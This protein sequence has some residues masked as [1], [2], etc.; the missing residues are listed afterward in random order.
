MKTVFLFLLLSMAITVNVGAQELEHFDI[1]PVESGG[2]WITPKFNE[3]REG[4]LDG[5][6]DPDH[7][8]GELVVNAFSKL[9]DTIKQEIIK[10]DRVVLSLRFDSKGDVYAI[11][12]ML[13]TKDNFIL[14]DEQWLE[15]NN[16][17]RKIKVDISKLDVKEDF[18]QGAYF[19]HLDKLLRSLD[20]PETE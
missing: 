2:Y 12:I 7:H 6:Y 11:L 17:S 20:K 16:I 8:L 3:S 18:K 4:V 14:N 5:F 9:T 13:F 1:K 19:V 15:V 10:Y